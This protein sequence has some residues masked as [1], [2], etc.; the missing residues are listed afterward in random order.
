MIKKRSTNHLILKTNEC[1]WK[2]VL[3]PSQ[4]NKCFVLLVSF[5]WDLIKL[6]R[7]YPE[8]VRFWKIH[9]YAPIFQTSFLGIFSLFLDR[10]L[11][12]VS[13]G[14]I[15][16]KNYLGKEAGPKRDPRKGN[17]P[18]TEH[19]QK[20]SAKRDPHNEDY[21]ASKHPK[22]D[23]PKERPP[24]KGTTMLQSIPKRTS[25]KRDPHKGDYHASKHPRKDHLKERP[26]QR[27]LP[28]HKSSQK[29]PL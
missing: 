14:Q 28:Y 7:L 12:P 11:T 21:H 1:L 13:P 8:L 2:C 5:W 15:S 18:S 17:H 26:P 20:A 25:A 23:L 9:M 3:N 29:E 24:T 16:L 6:L 10:L 27:G 4:P 19:P 22:K